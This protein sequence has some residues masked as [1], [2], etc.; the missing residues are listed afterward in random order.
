[1]IRSIDEKQLWKY[2]EDTKG[3]S[4]IFSLFFHRDGG[5]KGV[6]LKVETTLHSQ[7][8]IGRIMTILYIENYHDIQRKAEGAQSRWAKINMARER[9]RQ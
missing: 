4:A 2:V 6:L 5:V 3:V 8:V 9:C 1:M 7:L